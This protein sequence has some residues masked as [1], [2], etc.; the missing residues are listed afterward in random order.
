MTLLF[1]LKQ[2][3]SSGSANLLARSDGV[4]AARPRSSRT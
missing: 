3:E 1:G 4:I 2:A